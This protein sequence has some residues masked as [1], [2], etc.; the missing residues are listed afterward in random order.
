MLPHFIIVKD[1]E[2]AFCEQEQQAHIQRKRLTVNKKA[3][4]KTRSQVLKAAYASITKK[5][6]GSQQRKT[7][8]P[9]TNVL[10]SLPKEAT[11]PEVTGRDFLRTA[12]SGISLTMVV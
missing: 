3:V 5:A 6:K 7:M 2:K 8:T 11:G 9:N 1:A 4:F 12:V 10:Y